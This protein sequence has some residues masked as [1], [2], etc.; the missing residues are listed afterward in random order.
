[1]CI[2]DTENTV[3]QIARNI[4]FSNILGKTRI[5]IEG[6]FRCVIVYYTRIDWLIEEFM[7][8]CCNTESVTH[9]LSVMKNVMCRLHYE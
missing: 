4:H 7:Q 3:R 2:C 8:T 5:F 1:M 9:R 6:L